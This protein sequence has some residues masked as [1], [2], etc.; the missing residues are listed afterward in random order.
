MALKHERTHTYI[1]NIESN[2]KNRGENA[3][4]K[5]TS[6]NLIAIAIAESAKAGTGG[7]VNFKA[8]SS[9]IDF[10]RDKMGAKQIGEQGMFIEGE[11]SKAV[12]ERYKENH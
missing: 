10:Y 9:L 11:A 2:P 4:F 8:K 1:S 3:E 12:L 5:H 7:C 6:Y